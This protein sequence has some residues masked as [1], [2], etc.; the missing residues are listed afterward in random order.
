MAAHAAT[1]PAA[2]CNETDVAS[3][4]TSATTAGS[5]N[6]VTIPIWY[7]HLDYIAISDALQR[8]IA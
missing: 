6:T 2:S 7:V 1:Y 4:I 3:A 5:G 8:N